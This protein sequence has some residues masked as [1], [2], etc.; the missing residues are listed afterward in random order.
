MAHLRQ[1]GLGSGLGFQ[2]F[3]PFKMVSEDATLRGRGWYKLL[4]AVV[5][6]LDVTV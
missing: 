3:N 6:I 5:L 1:S 2:A 4:D